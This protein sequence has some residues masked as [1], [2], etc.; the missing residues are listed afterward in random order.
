VQG[1][2]GVD[3]VEGQASP[4]VRY[5]HEHPGDP[6]TFGEIHLE[7]F[8]TKAV[9]ILQQRKMHQETITVVDEETDEEREVEVM[10]GAEAGN[11]RVK[12]LRSVLEY[13]KQFHP[14][15]VQINWA[16]Q[17]PYEKPSNPTGFYCWTESDVAAYCD[18]AL[19]P[20][21]TSVNDNRLKYWEK[22]DFSKVTIGAY[23]NPENEPFR[24]L[25][26]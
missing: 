3:R 11:R 17:V 6:L 20:D 4:A 7:N 14:E 10:R 19:K 12:Y 15:L 23:L 25:Y 8:T 26:Q 9:R 21:P 13:A 5:G 18:P 22:V 2:L 16:K 24:K 1:L